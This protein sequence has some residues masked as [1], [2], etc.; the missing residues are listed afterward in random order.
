MSFLGGDQGYG[1]GGYSRGGSRL[2]CGGVLPTFTTGSGPLARVI[3][4][5]TDETR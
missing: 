5:L 3:L 4:H 2:R 1:V